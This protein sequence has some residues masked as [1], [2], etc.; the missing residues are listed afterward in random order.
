[1]KRTLITGG[2]A[3]VS[4]FAAAWFMK[5]EYEVFNLMNG[6][7]NMEKVFQ[8]KIIFPLLILIL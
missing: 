1:M 8:E 7:A 6:I 5:K 3:F 2:T 4:K